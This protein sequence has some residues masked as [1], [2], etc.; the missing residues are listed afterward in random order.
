MCPL[1]DST[2]ELQQAGFLGGQAPKKQ[3]VPRA[4][5]CGAIQVL[6]RLN[7]N[8]HI[9]L[10]IDAMYVTKGVTHRSELEQGPNEDLWSIFFQL[11]DEHNG[12]TNILGVKSHLDEAG[13]AAIKQKKIEVHANSLA[14]VVAEAPE[15][16]P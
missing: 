8:T 3:T 16:G 12:N 13:P 14:D 1:S 15:N 11:I 7:D 10:P 5:L 2:F 6:S 4:E 9:Q